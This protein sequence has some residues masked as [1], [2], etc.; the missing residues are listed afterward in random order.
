M[1]DPT[2]NLQNADAVVASVR[3][4]LVQAQQAY[5]NT[6]SAPRVTQ[7]AERFE[8]PLRVAIAGKVKAGKSTLLNG[9]VGQELAP[10]DAG[11]CT[12]IITW[13]LDG[14]TYRAT[15]HP[16]GRGPVETPITRAD[17]SV[18]VDLGGWNAA[19]I[20]RITI[21]W[22]SSALAE[23]TLIDTPGIASVST[24]ISNRTVE[25]MTATDDHD[26]QADAVI[27]LMRH[28]HP[29]DSRF[30]ESFHDDEAAKPNPINAI[31]VLSRADE[32][33]DGGRHAMDDARRIAHRY[34]KD[35]KIRRLC[36][37]IVPVSGLLAQAGAVLRQ[38]DFNALQKLASLP[39]HELRL[40]CASAD[41]FVDGDVIAQVSAE[42]RSA[43]LGLLGLHGVR[44]STDLIAT[45]AAT[46]APALATRLVQESGLHELRALLTAQFADR[47]DILKARSTIQALEHLVRTAPPPDGGA[48]LE[49]ELE[50]IR[51]G[52][53]VFEQ[54]QLFAAFRAGSVVFKESDHDEVERLLGAQGFGA[55][56]RLG[57]DPHAT[58]DQLR[59]AAIETLQ[60]WQKRAASTLAS[61]EQVQAASTLVRIVEGI[62]GALPPTG[63]TSTF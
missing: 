18:D 45:G 33:G 17:H 44:L 60:R 10:T 42:D 11:E 6:E 57:L 38:A 4:L 54:L 12:K 22:P 36:Q 5:A 9:L 31:G 50:R 24:D 49:H 40:L 3:N 43:L 15:L 35:P 55:A 48:T 27:Y 63:A 58:H 62:Y 41:R 53:H 2:A 20:E 19:D 59:A 47:R 30:L 14:L 16:R 34:R 32:L 29:S 25:F 46:T 51:A 8:E 61:R 7:L 23:L 26:S 52:A 28:F 13:Y 56:A 1:S 39:A 21:E 37:T